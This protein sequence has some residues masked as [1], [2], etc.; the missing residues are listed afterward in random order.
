MYIICLEVIIRYRYHALK[1][2]MHLILLNSDL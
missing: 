1:Y 2:E